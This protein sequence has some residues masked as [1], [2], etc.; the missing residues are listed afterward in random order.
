[1][2]LEVPS[3]LIFPDAFWYSGWLLMG[4]LGTSVSNSSRQGEKPSFPTAECAVCCR[5]EEALRHW[6][7]GIKEVNRGDWGVGEFKSG[8]D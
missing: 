1:M 3:N 4:S 6:H 2:I 5:L 8:Q 7:K